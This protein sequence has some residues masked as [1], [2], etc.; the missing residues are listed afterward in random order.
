MKIA[1]TS[2]SFSGALRR[3]TLTHLEWLEAC[4]SRLNVDGV[5][6][7]HSDFPRTD[8]E[9]LAQVKKAATDLGLVPVA[10][11]VPGLLEPERSAAEGA[12]M[13]DVAA[14]LG[15]SLLRVTAGPPGD[16]PPETFARTVSATKALASRAKAANITLAVA[17]DP[18]SLLADIAAVQ[19]F[20]KY[21]DSAWLRYDVSVNDPGRSVLGARDRTLVQRIA[22]DDAAGPFAALDARA[23][24]LI[25][26]DGGDDP[27]GRAGAA[28]AALEERLGQRPQVPSVIPG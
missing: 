2:S 22:M 8:A 13:L 14:A 6:L 4:A 15:V 21:V 9:Y 25:D 5:V 28:L 19:N 16:L 23:W 1:L 12:A 3:G 18:A 10:L 7:A 11:D 27:L 26:G 24:I 20:S 17:G